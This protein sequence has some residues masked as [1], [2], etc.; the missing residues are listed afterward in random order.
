MKFSAAISK[1]L[2][3]TPAIQFKIHSHLT[4]LVEVSEIPYPAILALRRVDLEDLQIPISVY[5]ACPEEAY[6]AD[7]DEAK[8][9]MNNGFGLITVS[10]DGRVQPRS[11][12]IPL[13]QRIAKGE[14]KNEIKSLTPFIRR[15]L[16][17]AF[18]RYNANAPS[19]VVDVAEVLE[20]FIL[21]AGRDAATKKWIDK[22]AAAPGQPAKTLDALQ[23]AS[24][25]TGAMASI[26]SARG[27]IAEYRNTSHHFPKDKR[28]AARK[29][30]EC[31][32]AFLD[33]LKRICSFRFSMKASGLSGDL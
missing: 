5:C 20:G 19:G 27:Y 16:A 21:R 23:A 15:R 14:F 28:Q 2:G 31:R 12:C 18:E 29:Y 24:Q 3:Y 32:H 26:G 13:M 30:R 4:V 33:G 25:F 17:E 11:S 9:L 8:H 7:Q 6:L 10:K 22:D 1:N